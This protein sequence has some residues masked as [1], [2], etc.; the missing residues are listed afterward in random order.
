MDH[1][2]RELTKRFSE[3]EEWK[4]KLG[5]PKKENFCS[6]NQMVALTSPRSHIQIVMTATT[7]MCC[8]Q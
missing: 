6:I 2:C 1:I 4:E 5:K 7:I 3:R 8:V